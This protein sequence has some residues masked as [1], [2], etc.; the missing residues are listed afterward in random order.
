MDS[1]NKS[2]NLDIKLY[3]HMDSIKIKVRIH[4]RVNILVPQDE[5]KKTYLGCNLIQYK[6]NTILS[7]YCQY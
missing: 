1:Q 5:R 3:Q 6:I 2:L 4:L 7:Y